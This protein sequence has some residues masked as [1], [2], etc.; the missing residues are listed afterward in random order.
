[1]PGFG[2]P[3]YPVISPGAVLVPRPD[4][5][6]SM[7]RGLQ[8]GY[9]FGRQLTGVPQELEAAQLEAQRN[10][11]SMAPLNRAVTFES[12]LSQPGITQEGATPDA[13]PLGFNGLAFSPALRQQHEADKMKQALELWGAKRDITQADQLNRRY[14]YLRNM[15]SGKTA[16]RTVEGL[17]EDEAGNPIEEGPDWVPIS[18]LGINAVEGPGGQVFG[19]PSRQLP[20]Q[21]FPSAV[22]VNVQP[23]APAVTTA[24]DATGAIPVE[25]AA[26]PTPLRKPQ[27]KQADLRKEIGNDDVIINYRKSQEQIGRLNSAWDMA[28]KTNNFVAVDQVL[29]TALNKLLDPPS[30]VRESE[31]ARTPQNLSLL[32]N[33]RGRFKALTTGGAKLTQEDRAAIVDMANSFDQIITAKAGQVTSQYEKLATDNG[34]KPED[35]IPG[36]V[37]NSLRGKPAE[38][39]TSTKGRFTIRRKN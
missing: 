4:L 32:N 22:P 25:P 17:L 15:Q 26:S 28:Q 39:T 13:M 6:A 21:P 16:F 31:Y 34:F 24:G 1:M 36:D 10:A 8:G 29:I 5:G 27:E 20:G 12:L 23:Q 2:V 19:L 38:N 9:A 35:V 3:D 18:G 30:V 37:L 14:P 11:L 33:L 7:N